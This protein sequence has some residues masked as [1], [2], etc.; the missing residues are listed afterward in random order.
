VI[1]ED[2]YKEAARLLYKT[3]TVD[4]FLEAE[5]ELRFHIL[6]WTPREVLKGE[7]HL[8][9]N[10]TITLREA[11]SL[12]AVVKL[13]VV[14]YVQDNKYTEFS[15]IYS[16]VVNGKP[17][18]DMDAT[19]DDIRQSLLYY[20]SVGKW[21][22]VAK[23]MFSIAKLEE[24]NA[25]LERLQPVLNG[26]L[27]RLYSIIS[28]MDTLLYLMENEGVLPTNKVKFEIDQYRQR[29]GNIYTLKGVNTD[30]ILEDLAKVESLPQNIIGRSKLIQTI[31]KVSNRLSNALHK[32]ALEDLKK[33]G[34]YPLSSAFLP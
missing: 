3:H 23:R 14:A 25:V 18:N 29:L 33:V 9:D 10:R 24:R 2:E 27:G 21:F 34:L 28:D 20:V 5:K 11:I 12:P 32:Y 16:F 1:D 19:E 15:N 17:L 31:T 6:R 7:L 30:G 8:R 26:D 22:K 4:G 13:D